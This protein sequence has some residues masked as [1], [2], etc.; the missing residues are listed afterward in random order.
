VVNPDQL[1][2]DGDAFDPADPATGGD[3]CDID[4]DNDGILDDGD[5]S[6]VIGDVKCTGY[7]SA[8]GGTQADC[9]DNCQF[10]FNTEQI[11]ID[12]DGIGNVC[13]PDMDNDTVLNP[14]DNCPFMWNLDQANFD[15]TTYGPFPDGDEYGDICDPDDDNDSILDFQDE[16]PYDRNC[17]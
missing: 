15:L 13:D 5:D 11:D 8:S 1:N 7:G 16:C 17:N 10:N 4:D 14:D 3:A 12:S 6:G 9:D 2:N